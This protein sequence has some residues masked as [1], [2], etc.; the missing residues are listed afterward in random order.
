M[1][2]FI[3]CLCRDKCKSK[4]SKEEKKEKIKREKTG[5]P[6]GYVPTDADLAVDK[7]VK[8]VLEKKR[9]LGYSKDD[10]EKQIGKTMEVFDVT[11]GKSTLFILDKV[12]VLKETLFLLARAVKGNEEIIFHPRYQDESYCFVTDIDDRAL[13]GWL[14]LSD[15]ETWGHLL[16]DIKSL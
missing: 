14:G 1:G 2:I 5:Y 11:T 9:E 7:F 6:K 16:A 3:K 15:M 8:E 10:W 13:N 4:K 12:V